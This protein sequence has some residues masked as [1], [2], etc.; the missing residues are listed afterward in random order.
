MGVLVG[1]TLGRT[2]VPMASFIAVAGC[3]T[4]LLWATTRRIRTV[5]YAVSG[6]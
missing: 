5:P 3:V 2:A 6:G 4:L 1:S